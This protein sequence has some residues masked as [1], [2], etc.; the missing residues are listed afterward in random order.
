MPS[1]RDESVLKAFW[2]AA[3]IVDADTLG[4]GIDVTFTFAGDTFTINTATPG[5]DTDDEPTGP[6]LY[7]RI[8]QRV[9]ETVGIL[10]RELSAVLR[11]ASEQSQNM[12]VDALA[13]LVRADGEKV[14]AAVLASLGADTLGKVSGQLDLRTRA[15]LAGMV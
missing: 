11:D 15:T 13:E 2:R 3:G 7:S 1:S 8:E 6:G 10:P 12:L 4:A 5:W 9:L 14:L